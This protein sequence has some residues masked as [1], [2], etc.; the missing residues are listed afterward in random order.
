MKGF[1]LVE[2]NFHDFIR[3]LSKQTIKI[4]IKTLAFFHFGVHLFRL[5]CCYCYSNFSLVNNFHTP[6][7]S[8]KLL[9][10]FLGYFYEA[11][12]R[13]MIISFNL[14]DCKIIDTF[15]IQFTLFYRQIIERRNARAVFDIFC[16]LQ[17]F[18]RE[19]LSN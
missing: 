17:R 8:N 4:K 18:N 14:S 1:S 12:Y 9:S 2:S 16:I 11:N 10:R 6:I 19:I 7:I 13:F 15:L 3:C 5:Y